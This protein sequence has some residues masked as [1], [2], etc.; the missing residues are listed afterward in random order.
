M[1]YKKLSNEFKN[2]IV[3]TIKKT[4]NFNDLILLL[5]DIDAKMKKISKQS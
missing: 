2:L 3:I 4:K 5:C 1:L